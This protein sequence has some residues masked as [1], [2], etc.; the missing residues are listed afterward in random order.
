MS[1]D[2]TTVVKQ[3]IEVWNIQDEAA[4]RAAVEELFTEDVEYVDPNIAARGRD[5]VDGYIVVTQ[6]QL[7]GMVFWLTGE[8]STHH[9][10]A[11]FTWQCGPAGGAAVATGYDFAEVRDGKVRRLYGFFS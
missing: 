7:A 5:E 11:R 2:V 4:R 9:N 8:I 6:K 10:L 1:S 3:Y